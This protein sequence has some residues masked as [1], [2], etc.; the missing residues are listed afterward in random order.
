ML[1][2]AAAQQRKQS[3]SKAKRRPSVPRYAS[4]AGEQQDDKQLA[5][6]VRA[7][8]EE[9]SGA[10]GRL[11]E[12]ANQRQG[13]ELS[14]RAALALGYHDLSKGR[15]QQAQ[16]WLDRAERWSAGLGREWLL[17]EYLIYWQAQVKRALGQHAEALAQL[18]TF[19]RQF[20]ESVMTENAGELLAETAIAAGKPE[21]AIAA[22]DAYAKTASR[23]TLLLLRAQAKE[24]VARENGPGRVAAANDYLAVYYRFPLNDEAKATAPRISALKRALGRQFPSI[25]IE[26]QLGRAGALFES[27]RWRDARTEYESA[28]PRVTGVERQQVE[29]R[30]AQ[31]RV[32]LGA[33]PSVL[34]TLELTA[35]ELDAERLYALSQAWRGEKKEAEMLAAIE[36]LVARYPQNRW[37]EEGVFAAGNYFWVNLDRERAAGYYRR[38]LEQFPAGRNIQTALWRLAWIAYL[39]RRPE[40][41]SLMEEHLRRFPGSPYTSNALYWLGRASERGGN[42]PHARSF[43]RKAQERFPQSYFGRLAA[44]RVLGSAPVNSAD[45]L[46]LIPAPP[47]LPSLDEAIPP[48]ARERWERARALQTIAFDA[49]AELE[50]RAAYSATGVLRLLWAAA[51]A[52]V[53]AGRLTVGV[54]TARQVFP[55][56]EAR[57]I[58]EVPLTAW[59][60]VYPLPFETLLKRAAARNHM[61]PMLVA[62]VIRQESVFQPDAVSRAGAMGLMQVLPKTGRT[63]AGR[64][65]LRYARTRLFDPEYNLLLGALYLADLLKTQGSAEAALA[66]FNAG[67]DRVAA[68][69]AERRYEEPAEFV[70]SIPFTETRE[71]VQIVM[72]NAEL[73]RLLYAKGATTP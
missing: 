4:S 39:E 3:P 65:K 22:L 54:A 46:A 23:P 20:P 56:L 62:G 40:A 57:K 63:L 25:P 52:A 70:E 66:A 44:E 72:R 38:V 24:K 31:C 2:P 6:F 35:P 45:V 30:I 32:Q 58:E 47:P 28:L 42:V 19:R 41:A 33:R 5:Q 71:Y 11:A 68:W 10:Y 12:F 49:S 64:L 48:E 14:A 17:R 9:E 16:Q 7:V 55:Q 53:D 37:A 26:Q 36:Q 43:Y 29:L 15:A 60:T 1:L 27:H 34:A 73:Y 61:D 69:Q 18:E 13:S 8:R 51:Q 21:R 50:F 59:R 67:E